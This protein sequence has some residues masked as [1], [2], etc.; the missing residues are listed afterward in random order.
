MSEPDGQA[1]AGLGLARSGGAMALGTLASRATGFL[2]TAAVLAALGATGVADAYNVA[3]TTPNIVYDLLL[4]GVLSSVVVPLLV[5]AAREDD[6]GGQRFFSVLCTVTFLVLTVA[7]VLGVL[8]APL[9]MRLYLP[10]GVSPEKR[11][12]AVTFTRLF[13]PQLLF[14]AATALAGAAL[15]IRGRFG[16]VGAAPVVN[17]LVVIGVAG[18]FIATADRSHLGSTLSGRDT[19]LIGLGTT[20]GV[21]GMALAL[22]PSLRA[23]GVRIRFVPDWREPRLRLAGRLAGWVLGYAAVNQIGYLVITRLANRRPGDYTVYS[24][25]YQLFSLP[26][27]IIAVS[28]ISALMPGLSAAAADH[29]AAQVRRQLSRGLRLSFVLLIPAALGLAALAQ[30]VAVGALRYGA[31]S[32]AGARLIGD[33]LAAFALGLPAFSGYQL[34]LRAFYARQDSRTPT[35][36]NVLVNVVNVGADL[37]LIAVLPAHLRVPALAAGFALSY[38]AGAVAAAVLLRRTLASLDGGRIVRLAVRAAL[39]GLL[40][41][42]AA[43]VV[44]DLARAL[45]GAGAPAAAAAALLGAAAGAG[46]F[47]RAAARLRIRELAGLLDLVRR[48]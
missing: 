12:L 10:G 26:H 1:E 39:A 27:A 35:L 4:G 41:A 20:A 5:R 13:L 14:Y 40:A 11:A 33:T 28:V 42:A 44:A 23:A 37:V 21:V 17:N 18:A 48:R 34:L 2:R 16:A 15:N 32:P 7:T 47:V 29:D 24:A 8:G 31:T 19:L 43:R 25:A 38:L 6:D 30:P 45:L 9:L 46:L 22:L 36:I 3:N